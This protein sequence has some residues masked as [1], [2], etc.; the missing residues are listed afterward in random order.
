MR[1][2]ILSPYCCYLSVQKKSI[3]NVMLQ[4][5]R[6]ALLKNSWY[7]L[8]IGWLLSFAKHQTLFRSHLQNV[9]Y[10]AIEY[11]FQE[12]TSCILKDINH[13]Y[14]V[15]QK[16]DPSRFTKLLLLL[17][18][19]EPKHQGFEISF[20][21]CVDCVEKK[22]PR[23]LSGNITAKHENHRRRFIIKKYISKFSPIVSNGFTRQKYSF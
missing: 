4:E 3:K 12:A 23:I 11:I 2:L 17:L 8:R 6:I 14:E 18:R 9:Y 1:N 15:T 20:S 21:F 10:E 5:W 22:I 7:L 13:L 16:N 19:N